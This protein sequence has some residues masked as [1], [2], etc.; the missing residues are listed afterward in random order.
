MPKKGQPS[1]RR[2][3]VPGDPNDPDGLHVWTVRFLRALEVRNFSI[4]TRTNRKRMIGPFIEWCETRSITR[5]TEVTKPILEAYQRHLFH[6]RRPNGKPLGFGTQV[7]A[8]VSLK[9]FFSWLT[10]TN[11]LLYNPASDIELPRHVRRLPR[12]V[13]TA[14][15]AETVLAQPDVREPWGLRDRAILEVLYSTG[16]RRMEVA[17]L[18]VFDIVP[19][20][21]TLMVR[22]G[23]YGKD[24]VVPIGERALA[25]VEKYMRDARPHI[26][27]NPNDP[28]L[29]VN[30]WGEEMRSHALT[31]IATKYVKA[32]GIGRPGSCHMFRHTC[33]TLMLEGGADV[34]HVQE[35]LGHASLDSTAVYTHV[36]IRALREV[37][38]RTHPG[39]NLNKP[40]TPSTTKTGM[41]SKDSKAEALLRAISV[42]GDEDG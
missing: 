40:A 9:R 18:A 24:R 31:M 2:K 36:S 19:D 42:E 15:E 28:I 6:R 22:E 5:P 33:A 10:R 37:H 14:E 3:P 34:R 21:G 17:R 23:K 35:M 41:A 11:V 1:P 16:L 25:W 12:N 27:T 38:R 32:S 20:H 13:L 39:A 30:R 8:L 7:Q 29:F 4:C 26:L